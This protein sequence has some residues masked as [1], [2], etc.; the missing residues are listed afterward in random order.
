MIVVS[1]CFARE[2][3][4]I[5]KRPD[6]A[7]VHTAMGA[8]A[9]RDLERRWPAGRGI[10]VLVSTGVCGAADPALCTGDLVL[11]D[12]I[13]HRGEEIAVSPALID[14]VRRATDDLR[15]GPAASVDRVAGPVEKRAAHRAGA[16]TVDMES[17]PIGAWAREHGIDLLVLRAV[18]DRADEALPFAPGRPIWVGVVCHPIAALR[19]VR[20]SARA[21]RAI[22]RGVD[23][24]VA[25]LQGEGS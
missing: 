13:V 1:A 16:A 17:G 18:L 3:R 21:G 6:V 4:W 19:L 14:R 15:I 24:M 5:A 22:G 25:R 9:A 20:R 12:R 23:A 8:G 10:D 7:V 11:A 2:T